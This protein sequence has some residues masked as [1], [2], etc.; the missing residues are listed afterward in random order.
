MLLWCTSINTHEYVHP[1][2]RTA[3]AKTVRLQYVDPSGL[4]QSYVIELL[5]GDPLQNFFRVDAKY[6]LVEAG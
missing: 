2:T 4:V 5:A 6:R 1:D 3:V